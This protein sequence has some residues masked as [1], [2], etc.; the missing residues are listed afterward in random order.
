MLAPLPSCERLEGQHSVERGFTFLKD[1]RFLA[2]SVF[3]KK[4]E[5]IMALSLIIVL[6][7]CL[8]V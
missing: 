6:C 1:P 4:P 5:R 7:L 8:L 2:A 3:L